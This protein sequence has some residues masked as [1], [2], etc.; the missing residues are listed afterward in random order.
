MDPELFYEKNGA[1]QAARGFYPRS[2]GFS[3]L[4]RPS[5]QGCGIFPA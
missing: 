3:G 2:G 5:K 1:I 4:S